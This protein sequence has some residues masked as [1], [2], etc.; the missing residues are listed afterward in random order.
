MNVSIIIRV[1]NERLNL[2]KLFAIL[3]NQTN[4]DF[5]IIVV[6]NNST[7]GSEKVVLDFF[8]KDRVC[9][10]DIKDFSY[11]RACN[12]GAE[13]AKGKYLVYLSAHSFPISNTWL[14]DGLS[15][16]ENE[17]V[18]GVFAFPIPGKDSTLAEKISGIP[19]KIKRG[20]YLGNTNSIIRKDLW[21]KHKFDEGLIGSEDYEWSLY[22]EKKGFSVINEPKF[23][24]YHS[25]HLRFLGLIKRQLKWKKQTEEINNKFKT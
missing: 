22:W 14:A 20:G 18:A 23:Q 4:Q 8:P 16:F 6:N 25:H 19:N 24:V 3:K 13:K 17:K 5:E 7:D 1:K 21:E 12:L 9:V 11:P 15:N 10:V 2:E